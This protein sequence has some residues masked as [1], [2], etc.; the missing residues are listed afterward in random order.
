[1]HP[2]PSQAAVSNHFILHLV[3]HYGLQPAEIVMLRL[4]SIDCFV[5][6]I[7]QPPA[8]AGGLIRISTQLAAPGLGSA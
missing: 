3:E 4:D 6:S 1:M 7:R 8:P 2:I 5:G